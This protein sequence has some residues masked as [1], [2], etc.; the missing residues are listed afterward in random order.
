MLFNSM[1][2]NHLSDESLG[3]GGDDRFRLVDGEMSHVNPFEASMI[4]AFGE[5]GEEA[6][7]ERGSGGI[8]PYTG[9]REYQFDPLTLGMLGLSLYQGWKSTDMQRESS[10]IQQGL[11]D[12]QLKEL[13]KTE[14]SAMTARSSQ[15]DLAQGEFKQDLKN[16]AD[17]MGTT[18]EDLTKNYEAQVEKSGLVSGDAQQNKSQM[19]D[20]LSQSFTKGK[21]SLFGK[22]GQKMGGIEE[23]FSGE[24][25][26]IASDR[27]R[28]KQ[29]QRVLKEQQEQ[30]FLGIF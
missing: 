9:K 23:Y 21:E 26:R 22:L 27:D 13:D 6:V 16:Q 18:K 8:N 25:G 10:G 1:A 28:L 15:I 12:K 5:K 19:W 7:K 30:R 29:E 24:M 3:R 4:D 2:E 14:Q 17:E 20:R 11:V